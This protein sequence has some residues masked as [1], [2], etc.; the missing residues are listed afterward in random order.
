M[1]FK[2]IVSSIALVA[3][4]S[5][6]ATILN[7]STQN[8]NVRA[9]NGA[10]ISGT[11]DGKPFSAPGTV[12]IE[13]KKSPVTF[14]TDAAG[15]AKSTNVNSDVDSKFFINILS[16]GVFGS[17]TD[18]STGKMWRYANDVVISCQ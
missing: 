16:G 8:V 13:R 9:S 15:C 5:G 3:A 17:T 10:A 12:Q 4:C 6:C 2:A 14:T 7:D 18:Y 11:V 1:T